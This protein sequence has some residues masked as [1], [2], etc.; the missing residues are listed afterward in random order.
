VWQGDGSS[1]KA[2]QA[3]IF[4]RHASCFDSYRRLY[5]KIL[6]LSLSLF[7]MLS[8]SVR[9]GSCEPSG[10]GL[11]MAYAQ[12]N[13]TG[14]QPPSSKIV[15]KGKGGKVT[16]VEQKPNGKKKKKNGKKNN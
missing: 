4:G 9:D 10:I 5:V 3:G 14:R 11:P 16:G 6:I 8:L 13:K 15:I 1:A 7:F 12:N 2:R